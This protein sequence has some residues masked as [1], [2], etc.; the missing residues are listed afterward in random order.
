MSLGS[1][2]KY[3]ISFEKKK[4]FC[5]LNS[6]FS[7]HFIPLDPDSD[8]DPQTQ[9]NPNPTGSCPDPGLCTPNDKW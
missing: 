1:D 2:L 7:L 6:A 8:L 5:W 9:M 3:I 4:D